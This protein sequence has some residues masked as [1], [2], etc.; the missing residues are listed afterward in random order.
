[1]ERRRLQLANSHDGGGGTSLEFPIYLK[2]K[3]G[4]GDN[5]TRDTDELSLKIVDWFNKNC[6]FDGAW[7]RIDFDESTILYV[8]EFRI[9]SMFLESEHIVLETQTIWWQCHLYLDGTLYLWNDD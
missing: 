1:M 6:Q 5:R 7:N 4:S 3:E 8:D 9:Y 2:T